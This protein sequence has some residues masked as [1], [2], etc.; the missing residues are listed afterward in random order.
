MIL[1]FMSAIMSAFG[2][3]QHELERLLWEIVATL[4]EQ[5]LFQTRLEEVTLKLIKDW[6]EQH[7]N[8]QWF[9]INFGVPFCGNNDLSKIL[10]FVKAL[11]WG[12]CGDNCVVNI[13]LMSIFF[14]VL[15]QCQNW[16]LHYLNWH[17]S[18]LT[19][20]FLCKRSAFEKCKRQ[21]FMKWLSLL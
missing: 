7:R 2:K 14:G 12:G 5:K 4:I 8:I 18:A 9:Y 19:K 20:L 16:V 13:S 15:E 17:I 6:L 1:L 21:F 3:C 11:S 10:L